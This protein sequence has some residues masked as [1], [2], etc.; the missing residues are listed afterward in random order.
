MILCRSA[1]IAPAFAAIFRKQNRAARADCERALTI[2]NEEAI[3]GDGSARC[4]SLPTEAAV[5]GPQNHAVSADSPAVQLVRRE[6]NTVDRI[7]L[8]Q[9]ILPFP[10]PVSWLDDGD[11]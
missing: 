8:R 1:N 6:A 7:A 3:E 11:N 9:R 4:L 10:T 5:T 2:E